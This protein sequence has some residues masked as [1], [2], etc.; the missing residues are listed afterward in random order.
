MNRQLAYSELSASFVAHVFLISFNGFG[1]SFSFRTTRLKAL[2]MLSLFLLYL[3]GWKRTKPLGSRTPSN[4]RRTDEVIPCL[5]QLE[6]HIMPVNTPGGGL[7]PVAGWGG[8]LLRPAW[9][10]RT[11]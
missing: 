9:P 10:G 3:S 7:F 11:R 8:F 4:A 5:G 6:A 2:L 1:S